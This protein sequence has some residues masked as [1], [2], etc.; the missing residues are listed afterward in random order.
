MITGRWSWIP[1]L[2]PLGRDDDP[3]ARRTNLRL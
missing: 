3:V 1:T 2:A